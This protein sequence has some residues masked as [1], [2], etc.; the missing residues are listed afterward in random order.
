[1]ARVRSETRFR[2]VCESAISPPL[3][4]VAPQAIFV[5]LV[6]LF[7]ALTVRGTQHPDAAHCGCAD[8]LVRLRKVT[9][10]SGT[11]ALPSPSRTSASMASRPLLGTATL[12]QILTSS[13]PRQAFRHWTLE[14][15]FL[16]ALSLA[17][18]LATPTMHR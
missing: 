16:P 4:A 8:L 2:C 13:T 10:D 6:A 1:M 18:L 9:P 12:R 17:R 7:G 5:T 11:Q 3:T 15:A 14:A